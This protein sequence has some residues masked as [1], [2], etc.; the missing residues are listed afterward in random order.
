MVLL[1]HLI[2]FYLEV[3]RLDELFATLLKALI[4]TLVS[5][6]L[7]VIIEFLFVKRTGIKQ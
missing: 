4:S 6:S 5:V 3:F 2:L 7:I 1:H